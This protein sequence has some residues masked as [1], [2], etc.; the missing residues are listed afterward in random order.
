[1]GRPFGSC[2]KVI[3]PMWAGHEAD[4]EHCI[5]RNVQQGLGQRQCDTLQYFSL[6]FASGLVVLPDLMVK[7]A[8]IGKAALMSAFPLK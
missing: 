7:E 3:W 6:R 1:M 5:T 2:G 8:N 4:G